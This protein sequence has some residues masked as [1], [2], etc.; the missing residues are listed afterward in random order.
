MANLVDL[1]HFNDIDP[2]AV[3]VLTPNLRIERRFCHSYGLAQQAMGVQTWLSP[4]VY[5]LQTWLREAWQDLQDRAYPGAAHVA[6]AEPQHLHAL[7]ADIIT[8]DPQHE[9]VISM[10]SLAAT[11]LEAFRTLQLWDIADIT[12]LNPDP[13]DSYPRWHQQMVDALAQRHWVTTETSVGIIASAIAEGALTLPQRVVLFGFDD[14][15]PLYQRL[16]DQVKA[17]G[18][19]LCTADSSP[20]PQTIG[21]IGAPRRADQYQ[22]AARWAKGILAKTPDATVAIV[23]PQL[24]THRNDI[25]EA[26]TRAFEPQA[27][28]PSVPRY[29]PPFNVSVGEPLGTIPLIRNALDVLDTGTGSVD[30]A[31]LS[32]LLRS[33]YLRGADAEQSARARFDLALRTR[34]TARITFNSVI[35]MSSC[36]E[37]LGTALDD[38]L[39]HSG[40]TAHQQ[41][42]S[43]WAYHF[44]QALEALGWPGDRNLDSEE[45]QALSHW[46]DQLEQLARFDAVYTQ[47]SRS[48]AVSLLRQNVNRTVFQPETADSPLQVLGILEAAGLHFDHLWVMDLND[49]IW[50]QAP[51]PNPFIPLVAQKTLQMPHSSADRELAFSRRIIERLIAGADHVVMS[52]AQWDNDKELRCSSLIQD[53]PS[54]EMQ[55]LRLAGVDDYWQL[56]RGA[57]PI[58]TAEDPP[59]P[60]AHTNNVRGGAGLLA[61]QAAC[62]FQAFATYRL[63]ATQMPDVTLGINHKERGELVHHVLEHI[64]KKLQTQAALI[65]L[66][67]PEQEQLIDGAIDYALFWLK[68]HRGDLGARLLK[69]E[70]QRLQTVITQWLALERQRPPFMVE[71]CEGRV[72]AIIGGLPLTIRRDRVDSVAGQRLL[73]DYKIGSAA[74]SGW[75]GER[76]DAPQ[77]PLYVVTDTTGCAGAALGQVRPGETLLK[78]IAEN[79][80]LAA[81]VIP[82]DKAWGALPPSWQAIKHHWLQRLE[83]LAQEYREGCAD[84][85]PKSTACQTCHLSVLCGH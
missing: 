44:S 25:K 53:L 61:A 41:K 52:F 21:R 70:R 65:A 33:P 79:G 35:H 36:P 37:Q 64:W 4:Q 2:A 67:P 32:A 78:G 20:T 34:R 76:P 23:C 85:A 68:S 19:Q 7:W 66:P 81:G 24:A 54:L 5:A 50:P 29:T 55:D 31:T 73:I 57:L 49:D 45:Y 42:P 82:A 16:F 47:C 26:L 63:N 72:N 77:V 17:A 3:L 83:A 69:L 62:P 13:T 39:R 27:L 59:V 30:I 15:P 75:A 10:Q 43:R 51:Q 8:H 28:L 80:D 40:N 38:F 58:L 46:H 9:S 56:L 48:K 6:L 1:S 18:S 71:E 74:L 14:I 12:S 22:L 84:V 60:L 11:A